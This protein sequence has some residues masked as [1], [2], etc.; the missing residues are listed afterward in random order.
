[1]ISGKDANDEY[2]IQREVGFSLLAYRP[3]AYASSIR[4]PF[5]CCLGTSDNL[6]SLEAG[7]AAIRKV[8]RGEV[9]RTLAA[10]LWE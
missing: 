1:M 4:V 7:H 5:F 2:E 9:V 3:T 10:R 8:E 6:V